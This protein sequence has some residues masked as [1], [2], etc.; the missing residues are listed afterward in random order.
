M[1]EP[2]SGKPHDSQVGF[3]DFNPPSRSLPLP[4]PCQEPRSSSKSRPGPIRS[5][6]TLGRASE[7]GEVETDCVILHRRQ[8]Q[9]NM[10]KNSEAYLKYVQAVPQFDRPKYFPRTPNK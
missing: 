9:I 8:K 6:R 4:V 1:F 7:P 2:S 3:K 5:K 10:G